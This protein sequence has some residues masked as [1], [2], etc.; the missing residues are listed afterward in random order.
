MV[1]ER[2]LP[3]LALLLLLEAAELQGEV[4][5]GGA[6]V[7]GDQIVVGDL[8]AFLR[9]VP[10]PADVLDARAVV[11]DQGVVYGDDPVLAV[12][13]FGVSLKQIQATL[14][15]GL[16]IPGIM[17][18]EAVE[19][20]G[21]SGA[22]ELGVNPRDRLAGGD[23]EPRQVLGEVAALRLVGKQVAELLQGLADDLGVVDDAG[24]GWSLRKRGSP[25]SVRKSPTPVTGTPLCKRSGR[26]HSGRGNGAGRSL[27]GPG[28]AGPL[29]LRPSAG[30]SPSGRSEPP[31]GCRT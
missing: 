27:L 18:D 16:G 5:A 25:D 20:G 23:V 24:H 26:T 3:G 2:G 28:A 15:E 29:A 7:V 10:E 31:P 11:V 13:G 17:V 9:V 8:V 30:P 1:L 22:S 12:A 21:V 14:I 19:A 6:D 4:L